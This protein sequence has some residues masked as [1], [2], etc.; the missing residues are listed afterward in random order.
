MD[1][2]AALIVTNIVTKKYKKIFYEI[3]LRFKRDNNQKKYVTT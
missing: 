3:S 1:L 2:F